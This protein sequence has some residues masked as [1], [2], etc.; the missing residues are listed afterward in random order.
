[1]NYVTEPL[2]RSAERARQVR[3]SLANYAHAAGV[4]T[5]SSLCKAS[6]TIDTCSP[7]SRALGAARAL[8]AV[9]LLGTMLATPKGQLFFRSDNYPDGVVCDRLLSDASLFCILRGDQQPFAYVVTIAVLVIVVWGVSPMLSA[10]PHAWV[11]WSFNHSTPIP[12]GGDQVASVLTLFFVPLLLLDR[13]RSHWDV[14]ETYKVR[15]HAVRRTA[16]AAIVMV[17][18][19]VSVI[20]FHAA[21]GKLPVAEWSDGTVLWYWIQDPTFGP[22]AALRAVM[23]AGLGTLVGTVT[24]T[25]AVLL[26]ELALGAS[27]IVRSTLRTGLL[28]AGLLFHLANAVVFGL[29]SFLLSMSAALIIYLIRPGDVLTPP[30]PRPPESHFP[31]PREAAVAAPATTEGA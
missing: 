19:Q 21:I 31:A 26:L 8:L 1:M 2:R 6:A 30:P 27:L 13:R 15:H 25:Y 28:V 22:P 16:W 12:D 4:A 9:G 18:I 20:Y 14:D 17:W 11:A 29:W 24:V 23:A 7:F 5:W 3:E 10:V